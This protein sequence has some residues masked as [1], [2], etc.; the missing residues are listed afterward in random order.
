MYI[1]HISTPVPSS[2][3][4]DEI[5]RHIERH[6]L[7]V[8]GSFT[9]KPH[10][11]SLNTTR[12]LQAPL[13]EARETSWEESSQA[14]PDA[15]IL[16]QAI[17]NDIQQ[18]PY[19]I[20]YA[21][22]FM[23][24]LL[25]KD[26]LIAALHSYTKS[27]ETYVQAELFSDAKLAAKNIIA[28][29]T[30]PAIR[31][32]FLQLQISHIDEQVKLRGLPGYNQQQEMMSRYL[33]LA[34]DLPPA[35]EC[36]HLSQLCFLE[37]GPLARKGIAIEER[38]VAY[39]DSHL[40]STHNIQSC[41]VMIIRD[42]Q[43]HKTAMAHI[44]SATNKESLADVFKEFPTDREIHV[45]LVGARSQTEEGKKNVQKIVE[46]LRTYDNVRVVSAD[47]LTAHCPS[48]ITYNPLDDTL[49]HGVVVAK[50]GSH[51]ALYPAT[52]P[53]GIFSKTENSTTHET[54]PL[55]TAVSLENGKHT[56]H[57]LL[58]NRRS[59]FNVY[60]HHYS[61]QGDGDV[62]EYFKNALGPQSPRHI[63]SAL[64]LVRDANKVETERLMSTVS[65][66]CKECYDVVIDE[67][68]LRNFLLSAP[69]YIGENAQKLNA[70][71]IDGYAE[72]FCKS[73]NTA[74]FQDKVTAASAACS[75]LV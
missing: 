74:S 29:F 9:E 47:I 10:H 11:F 49:S 59:L 13:N 36:E 24:D 73:R 21:H 44:N 27:L 23:G 39:T 51:A 38:Q 61:D 58:L 55:H 1:N 54:L 3:T 2:L 46:V 42:P 67:E 25:K 41:V 43:T 53:L 70:T 72:R 6:T 75:V 16:A 30:H 22:E 17:A 56:K 18:H 45:R 71:L 62:Y 19:T 8:F 12:A 4:T 63:L 64:F 69:K 60:N 57:P 40:L 5:I 52:V 50:P 28:L 68:S 7:K 15:I 20:A 35:K 65:H 33:L 34:A 37:Q 31:Q 32:Q 48:A 66:C 26:D 14:V